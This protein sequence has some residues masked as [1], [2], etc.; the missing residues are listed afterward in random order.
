MSDTNGLDVHPPPVLPVEADQDL[1]GSF[2]TRHHGESLTE[3]ESETD[4][5][6]ETEAVTEPLTEAEAETEPL[7][8][9]EAETEPLTEAEAETEPLT[10]AE[11]ETEPFSEADAETEPE[12][13]AGAKTGLT[14][15]SSSLDDVGAGCESESEPEH[16]PETE[17]GAE[18][19]MLR[20]ARAN[21][22]PRTPLA[23]EPR[24]DPLPTD[25]ATEPREVMQPC[26]ASG[27]GP[28]PEDPTR[29]R[30]EPL[31]EASA[32]WTADVACAGQSMYP[33]PAKGTRPST[34]PSPPPP[35]EDAPDDPPSEGS[36]CTTQSGDADAGIL[37]SVQAKVSTL[38]FVNFEAAGGESIHAADADSPSQ[39]DEGVLGECEGAGAQLEHAADAESP[40]KPAEA[41]SSA[42]PA[43]APVQAVSCQSTAGE[44]PEQAPASLEACLSAAVPD[45]H[46]PEAG[47]PLDPESPATAALSDSTPGEETNI[48]DSRS[49]GKNT[50]LDVG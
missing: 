21:L 48:C 47:S 39:P 4:L 22:S 37:P 14:R 17:P 6:V 31:A 44:A 30:N 19:A 9:A 32:G 29:A 5:W 33:H 25:N 36:A 45:I 26:E 38:P 34:P 27:R 8:E 15:F 16:E 35:P 20:E 10:E 11:A 28:V 13:A 50:E 41:K 43:D 7:T 24:W 46:P 40:S 3:T 18:I 23:D 1:S 42:D 49:T 12:I 2:A